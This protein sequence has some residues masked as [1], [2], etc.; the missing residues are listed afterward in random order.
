MANINNTTMSKMRRLLASWTVFYQKT[1]T[2]HW[3]FTGQ[4]FLE[5]HEHMKKLYEQSVE[6]S[7]LVAE[8]MRQIGEKINLTLKDA[9]EGSVVEDKNSANTLIEVVDDLVIAYSQIL[10]L[11]NEIFLDSNEQQDYV[12]ADLMTQLSKNVE[13]NSW[14][15]TSLK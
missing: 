10:L 9:V 3:D 8:R 12:T 7:D 13:F 6:N 4:Q 2:Y 1:H 15:L 14:F 5:F 11:Q